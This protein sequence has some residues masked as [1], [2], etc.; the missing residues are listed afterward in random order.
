M[1]LVEPGSPRKSPRESAGRAKRDVGQQRREAA[2][3]RSPEAR[4]RKQGT[5][6]RS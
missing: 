6:R 5:R 1:R 4:A 2:V 3:G